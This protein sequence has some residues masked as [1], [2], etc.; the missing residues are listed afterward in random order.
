MD[1]PRPNSLIGMEIKSCCEVSNE[2]A[3]KDLPRPI[4]STGLEIPLKAPLVLDLQVLMDNLL[5]NGTQMA[6]KGR[7]ISSLLVDSNLNDQLDCNGLASNFV[8]SDLSHI[9]S[10]LW[11][12]WC[13]IYLRKS[14]PLPSSADT[15]V[16]LPSIAEKSISLL[17]SAE[18]TVS[19]PSSTETA[20]SLPSPNSIQPSEVGTKSFGCDSEPKEARAMELVHFYVSGEQAITA[21]GEANQ[22]SQSWCTLPLNVFC[23]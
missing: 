9:R 18:T 20:I 10:T 15:I 4:S 8:G 12:Q 21:L 11:N 1:L 6:T 22:E 3:P 2:K 23:I 5:V 13:S 17:S 7:C 14:L 16:S 19:I